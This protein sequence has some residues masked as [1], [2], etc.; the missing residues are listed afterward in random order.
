[1]IPTPK[2]PEVPTDL[3]PSIQFP[4]S[5]CPCPSP[6]QIVLFGGKGKVNATEMRKPR[7]R[8][9]LQALP[10]LRLWS[11]TIAIDERVWIGV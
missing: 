4:P 1:M 5:S 8:A 6:R 7:A 2:M 3:P 10:R 9:M 11:E